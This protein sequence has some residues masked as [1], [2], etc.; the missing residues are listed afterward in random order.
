MTLRRLAKTYIAYPLEAIAVAF[1]HY[2]LKLTSLDRASD[3]GG[4][5]LRAM[6]PFYR[7]L[8]Q[9]ALSNLEK[10]FPEKSLTERQEITYA[11]WDN[12]GRVVAEYS[13]LGE[14]SC[15]KDPSII[16]IIGGEYVDAARD[17]DLPGLFLAAHYANW[18]IAALAI[19]QRGLPLTQIYRAANNS[20]VNHM[21]RRAQRY[22]TRA[23]IPKNRSGAKQL[24]R[25]M[26]Q[27]EHM[28]M[29]MDQ[30]MNNG[31][32]VP[33]FGQPVMT[34][35]A[36]GRLALHYQCPVIPVQVIRIKRS[37]RFEVR[38]SKPLDLPQH[39]SDEEKLYALM[40]NVNQCI[41]AWIRERPDLW[42]W[43]HS[44]WGK[45]E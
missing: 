24:M 35:S 23:L 27:R 41:E 9:L 28:M 42:L 31:L 32:A 21:I 4:A 30:R 17:D 2:G 18:E 1:C 12:L 37:S 19:I 22:V 15:Q 5:V 16:K 38:F 6:G 40:V 26:N 14:L 3:I 13:H 25:A 20:L 45:E 33:F 11:M 34:A 36:F 10:A 7:P 44:R 39:G 8:E 43:I 29:M